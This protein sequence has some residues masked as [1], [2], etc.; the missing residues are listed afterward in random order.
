MKGRCSLEDIELMAAAYHESGHIVVALALDCRVNGLELFWSDLGR[1]FG[2]SPV[3]LCKDDPQGLELIMRIPQ[4]SVA[5]AKTALAGMLAQ[6]THEG[7][8]KFG[9]GIRFDLATDLSV[10]AEFLRDNKR[11]EESPGSIAFTFAKSGGDTVSL[12]LSG[13]CFSTADSK[14]FNSYLSKVGGLDPVALTREAMQLIDDASNW[15]R[16]KEMTALVLSQEAIGEDKR[17]ALTAEQ[18]LEALTAEG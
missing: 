17:R 8:R 2:N 9:D 13:H 1:W 16:I 18:L 15:K 3:R 10:M 5:G 11:T 7:I 12:E 14:S 4:L 6:A